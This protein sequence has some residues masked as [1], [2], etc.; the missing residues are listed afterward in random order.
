MNISVFGLGYV[1]AVSCACLPE[2]GHRV[3]GVDTNPQKT[4]MINAG[5]SPVVE[6]GI[7]ELIAKAVDAGLL[8]A[9]ASVE[10]AVLESEVSLISV[11]TPSNP[12]FTPNLKAVEQVV[13]SI[14]EVLRRK[15][16]PHVVVLRS[17]VPPGTTE[18]RILPLLE[19]ELGPQG[20]RRP[21]A[22]LQP[23]VPARG[24]VGEGLPPAAADGG[25]QPR[26]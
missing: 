14:G 18:D 1:G 22:G 9:T 7:D 19:A 17:T 13:V 11:A 15:R 21:V 16:E 8:S 10:R 26:S 23:R 6:E 5:Q 4:E 24:L 2:L 3:I 12:N 20:R 25:R